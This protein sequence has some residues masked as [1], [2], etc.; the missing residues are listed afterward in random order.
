M[1]KVNKTLRGRTK[2][3]GRLLQQASEFEQQLVR[4]YMF[5]GMSI[6]AGFWEVLARVLGGQ[7][8]GFSYFF[9]WFWEVKLNLNKNIKKGAKNRNAAN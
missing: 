4:N 8:P 6:L 7:H 5:L 1:S 9:H 2:I 3:E